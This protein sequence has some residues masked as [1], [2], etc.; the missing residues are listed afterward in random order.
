MSSAGEIELNLSDGYHRAKRAALAFSSLLILASLAT[1][2]VNLAGFSL[3][4]P[5]VRLVLWCAA[6]YHVG[7][8]SMEYR[9][10]VRRH[11]PFMVERSAGGFD[12]RVDILTGELT[13]IVDRLAKASVSLLD[14]EHNRPATDSLDHLIWKLYNN[15]EWRDAGDLATQVAP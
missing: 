5:I 9:A 2:D 8:F 3:H 12:E 4:N 15:F 6:A 10:A 11:S 13:G 1:A 14:L 7:L